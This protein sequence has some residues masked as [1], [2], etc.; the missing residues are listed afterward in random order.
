MTLKKDKWGK[1]KDLITENKY[2]I[3][4]EEKTKGNTVR[5]KIV[6]GIHNLSQ[7]DIR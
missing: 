5:N 4:M 1:W 7:Y 2:N 6:R 3:G